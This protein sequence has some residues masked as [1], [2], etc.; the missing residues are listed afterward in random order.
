MKKIYMLQW[1]G[2]GQL[3]ANAYLDK[4]KAEELANSGNTKITRFRKFLCGL[5]GIR[6]EWI[7]KEI[8]VIE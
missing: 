7:V 2:N 3:G 8:P 6:A 5:T 4:A 1:A